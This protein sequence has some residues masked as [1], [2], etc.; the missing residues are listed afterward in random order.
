VALW[1][2]IISSEILTQ[3]PVSV[4]F[5]WVMAKRVENISVGIRKFL[6]PEYDLISVSGPC[7]PT[8]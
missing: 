1:Y 3:L 8:E 6:S 4:L 7:L 2:A 5:F